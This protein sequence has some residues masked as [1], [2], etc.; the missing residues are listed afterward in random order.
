MGWRWA[1]LQLLLD[2]EPLFAEAAAPGCPDCNLSVFP[3]QMSGADTVGDDDEASQ[4]RKS[5][6]LYVGMIHSPHLTL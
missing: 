2:P 1:G 5:K 6:N 3:P 4:K